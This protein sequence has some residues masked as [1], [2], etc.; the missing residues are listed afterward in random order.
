MSNGS[1][2]SG[3]WTYYDYECMDPGEIHYL[4]ADKGLVVRDA[5]W[6]GQ[7]FTYTGSGAVTINGLGTVV[8]SGCHSRACSDS[9]YGKG[10]YLSSAT[11]QYYFGVV[12]GV[13][14][15]TNGKLQAATILNGSGGF[16]WKGTLVV[17]LL[18]D[19]VWC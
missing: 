16:D 4:T 10:P 19:I 14:D 13:Y 17:G 15:E 12:K 8:L 1:Q 5:G 6:G 2:V 9:Y 18:D 7:D 11:N 3:S